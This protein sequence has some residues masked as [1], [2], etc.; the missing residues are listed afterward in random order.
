VAV[1][2][3]EKF[4]TLGHPSY[5]WRRGQERRLNLVR[6]YV[7]LE[8]QRILDVGCGLG[9]Y[10]RRLR[11]FSEHVWGTDI[12]PEKASAAAA[13][14]P[15]IV[16]GAAES[17]PFRPDSF[18]VVLLNEVLEHVHDD[19]ETII[20]AVRCVHPGGHVVVF[21]PN[22]LYP[23]E[24]HGFFIGRRYYFRLLPLINYTPDL[25][26]N[27]FCHHVRIYT[28]RG[29]ARLFDGLPVDFVVRSH[30]YPGLDNI[31]ARHRSLGRLLHSA[32]DVAEKTPL[33]ALGIS[34]FVVARKREVGVPANVVGRTET[35]TGSGSNPGIHTANARIAATRS[36]V[37][38]GHASG[39]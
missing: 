10:V 8:N 6:S 23:F 22:R 15:H 26:R 38:L 1:D 11:E 28:G 17:L 19:R 16:Q 31:A 21:A 4:V 20:E 14:L 18:D 35:M 34:H 27:I 5:V 33:R 32:V 7:T 36:I 12:D 9:T 37:A 13:H 30:I 24:T 2:T 39:L 25:I 29:L 3:T